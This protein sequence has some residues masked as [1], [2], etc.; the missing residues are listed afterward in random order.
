M[1]SNWPEPKRYNKEILT[2]FGVLAEAVT[3]IRN[4]RKEKQ[5]GQ[6]EKLRLIIRSKNPDP[7]FDSLIVKL[8]NLSELSYSNTKPDNSQTLLVHSVENFIP[9]EGILDLA[10]ES[11]KIKGELEYTKGFLKSVMNKLDNENFVTNA[12]AKV[13]ELERKKQSDAEAKIKALE[14]QLENL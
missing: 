12:P 1:V 8:A 11:K 14:I 2:S 3:G 9:F 4:I 7:F 13:I 6:K 5:L 10:E